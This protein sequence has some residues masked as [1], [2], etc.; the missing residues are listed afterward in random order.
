MK[1]ILEIR[2]ILESLAVER[3]CQ[4]LSDRSLK[5]INRLHHNCVQAARNENVDE[6]LLWNKELHHSIY[7]EANMPTLQE[8]IRFLWDRVSPYLYIFLRETP[9]IGLTPIKSL[10]YHGA[11][12]KALKR[13]DPTE[14]SKWLRIDLTEG[15]R[16]VTEYFDFIRKA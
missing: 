3:A 13:R 6:F 9:R 16:G 14:A 2:L 1:E 7:R 10:Q 12:L 4:N 8:I 11:M 5:H 15:L